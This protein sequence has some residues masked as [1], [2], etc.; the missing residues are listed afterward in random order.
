MASHYF[1]IT[2][3]T[4][5]L[6]LMN[7]N[8]KL[9]WIARYPYSIPFTLR[10][11]ASSRVEG[12]ITVHGKWP[13]FS[14]LGRVEIGRDLVVEGRPFPVEFGA[15]E[16]GHLKLGNNVRFNGCSIVANELITIGD[17]SGVGDSTSV[18][19]STYHDLSTEI[20]SRTEPI[21]IGSNVWIGR[22]CT[23]LPGVSIGDGSV[24]ASNSVVTK[25][26]PPNSL[27]GG[28]PAKLLKT[29][30][31]PEGWVRLRQ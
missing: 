24:V 10:V 16:G 14:G 5:E 26:V 28:V 8:E 30:D 22:C 12:L 2:G 19:D 31:I 3:L 4:R 23:I 11:R 15:R 13:L 25:S 27:V 1:L 9:R 6:T 29:L 21:S 18:M 7:F 17:D 20:R